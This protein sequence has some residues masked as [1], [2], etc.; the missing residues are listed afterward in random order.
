VDVVI[1]GRDEI[2]WF[3]PIRGSGRPPR[4]PIWQT[5]TGPLRQEV[6]RSILLPFVS[7]CEDFEPSQDVSKI[8]SPREND[9]LRNS[10]AVAPSEIEYLDGSPRLAR[11]VRVLLIRPIDLAIEIAI[12]NVVAQAWHSR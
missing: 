10:P 8:I 6:A 3:F 12:E 1:V 11:A 2:Q 7:E 9:F 4:G 5:L